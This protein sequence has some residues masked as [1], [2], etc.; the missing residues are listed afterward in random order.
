M[1]EERADSTE[2]VRLA[3]SEDSELAAD[4]VAVDSSDWMDEARL[5]APEVMDDRSDET[6]DEAEDRTDEMALPME[7]VTL[8]AELMPE[9]SV[10]M[11]MLMLVSVEVDSWA[12]WELG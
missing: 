8:A 2:L 6:L 10:G 9:A 11:L 3:S 7:E 1:A 12:C 5:L 4:P